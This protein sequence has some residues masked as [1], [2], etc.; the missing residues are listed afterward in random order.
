[1]VKSDSTHQ[2]L[3]Y[4]LDAVFNGIIREKACVGLQNEEKL[5]IALNKD[6]NR[7]EKSL[8]GM[9]AD[10]T[11]NRIIKPYENLP[12]E[13]DYQIDCAALAEVRTEQEEHNLSKMLDINMKLA[14]AERRMISD[15]WLD[16]E[17]TSFLKSKKCEKFISER[18]YIT[19][20]LSKEE[21]DFPL[22]YSFVVHKDA[23]QV[24]RLLRAVYRPQ[25]VYC[26]HID[27]KADFLVY[28]ALKRVADCFPNV[29]L[30]KK[31]ED[32]VYAT[33]SML[34]AHLNCMEELLQVPFC[35]ISVLSL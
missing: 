3:L 2:D 27:K 19:D 30:A 6:T 22:A 11:D 33:Y 35:I 7:L 23:G 1:M 34:Q 28:D 29:F 4:V 31:R 32:V 9:V 21:E 17:I 16:L 15:S 12:V 13:K 14:R 24:E 20:S 26:I 18:N 10:L 5:C 8:R 25:N